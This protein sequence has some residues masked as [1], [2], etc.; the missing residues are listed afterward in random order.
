LV[1]TTLALVQR[2]LGTTGHAV[3][4]L[5]VAQALALDPPRH[6]FGRLQVRG[7]DLLQLEAQQ[8]EPHG[9]SALVGVQTGDALARLREPCHG[10]LHV[11]AHLA[12]PAEQVGG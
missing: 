6:V 5:C 7:L 12:E 9:T 11:G 8:V 1:T 3:Q 4:R 10:R 2:L